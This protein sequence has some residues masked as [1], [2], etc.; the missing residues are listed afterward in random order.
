M[1]NK[2]YFE[3]QAEVCLRLALATLNPTL[4]ERFY[5][6]AADYRA[7][8]AESEAGDSLPDFMV[9]PGTSGEGE[10]GHE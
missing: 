1:T 6:M 4:A 3:K 7:R 2:K 9:M 5:E 8:A 10:E